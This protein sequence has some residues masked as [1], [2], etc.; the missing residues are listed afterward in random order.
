MARIEPI[1]RP[2]RLPV[3]DGRSAESQFLRRVRAGLAEQCG[4]TPTA[5]Q[6]LLIDRIAVL[7]LRIQ[8]IDNDPMLPDRVEYLDLTKLLAVLLAQL[9]GHPAPSS[10]VHH[11][12]REAAA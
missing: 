2:G 12:C 9:A 3:G 8:L 10:T 4:G 7:S 6:H 11:P 1:S 5:T